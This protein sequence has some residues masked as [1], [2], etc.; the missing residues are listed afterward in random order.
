V[1]PSIGAIVV[2]WN[3]SSD[4]AACLS[5]LS[6]HLEGPIV[7][8]DN[9]SKDETI[10]IARSFSGV[11]IL[12]HP[13]NL[14]FAGGVNRGAA[15]LAT[16]YLLILNPD[17]ELL[18]GVEAL[19]A[20][21]KDGASGGLLLNEDGTVQNGFL[22]RAFPT[23]VSLSFEVLGINRLF[24]GNPVNRAYRCTGFDAKREQP[25][26]QPPGA[27]LC[28]KR[29]AFEAIGGL[30]ENFW[31]V[32]FEDVDFCRRLTLAGFTIRFTPL[33]RAMHRGGRSVKQ[34]YWPFKELAWYGSLLRYATKHFG[35]WS[36]RLVGLAVVAASVP[37]AFT[38]IFSRH[39]RAHAL[40]VYAR[41]M[42]LAWMSLLHGH[43]DRRRYGNQ[44]EGPDHLKDA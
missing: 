12:E 44:L 23:P 7:V 20:A 13:E 5:A 1:K 28:V 33:A 8:V 26:D 15:Q 18:S 21:A 14:G 27:F 2:T 38:G 29:S 16:D 37:R 22:A 42:R 40:G 39:Q 25:V 32:W 9:G 11:T 19:A 35:W 30:D 6:E 4:I 10:A 31:P 41:V 24:P 17:C 34:I 36:R 43:V 3:S